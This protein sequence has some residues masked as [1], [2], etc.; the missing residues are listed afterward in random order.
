MEDERHAKQ[1]IMSQL[2]G[3]WAGPTDGQSSHHTRVSNKC[4]LLCAIRI[5]FIQQHIMAIGDVP[6]PL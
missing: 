3:M 2:S 1:P 5:A 4:F 6:T